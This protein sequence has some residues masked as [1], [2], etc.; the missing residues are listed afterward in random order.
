MWI[1]RFIGWLLLALAVILAGAEVM[2]SLAA[3]HWTPTP[4]GKLW[5]DYH[6]GSLNLTQAVTQR[7]IWAPLWDPGVVTVLTWP[8]WAVSG[9]LGIVLMALFRRRQPKRKRWFSNS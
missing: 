3:G 9:G 4:L 1:G 2:H 8:A 6:R 7:Y 5:Y